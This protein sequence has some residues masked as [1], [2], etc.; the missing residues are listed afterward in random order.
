VK[1]WIVC[2]ESGNYKADAV[3]R[4]C[5]IRYGKD[6]SA[7]FVAKNRPEKR[8]IL[9]VFSVFPVCFIARKTPE[10][11]PPHHIKQALGVTE[12]FFPAFPCHEGTTS[13][14]NSNT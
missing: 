14:R 8:G 6:V 11:R 5:L 3:L 1:A 10:T 4:A 9:V 7:Y 12:K 2:P 13:F